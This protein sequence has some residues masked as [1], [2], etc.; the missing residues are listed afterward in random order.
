M[1]FLLFEKVMPI[2]ASTFLLSFSVVGVDQMALIVR[3][4]DIKQ[5][6]PIFNAS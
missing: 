1:G 3:Q 2:F 4:L 5:R 6:H